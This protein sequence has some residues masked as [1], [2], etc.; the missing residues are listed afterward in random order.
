MGDGFDIS[1][2]DNYVDAVLDNANVFMPKESKNFI[3]KEA[4]QL[5]TVNKRVYRSKGIGLEPESRKIVKDSVRI[6]NN[7]NSGKPYK[8][9]GVW[10]C[11]A[12]NSANHAHLLNNG[13]IHKPHKGEKGVEKFIPGFHFM[14]AG[15]Q[16][17]ES[18]YNSDCEGFADNL[19]KKFE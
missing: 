3:R 18:K 5:N 1:Q 8:F 7:F 4:R 6:I 10:S 16:E 11:R 17:F 9:D 13:W 12:Y 2:F 14:E 15:Q 19:A